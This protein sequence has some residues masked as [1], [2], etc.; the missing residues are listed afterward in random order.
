MKDIIFKDE[1]LDEVNDK[2]RLIQKTNGLTFGTDALLLAAF[3][4]KKGDRALELG[5]GSG[6]ISML[7]CARERFKHIVCAEVQTEYAE[8]IERNIVL[9]RLSER[10]MPLCADIRETKRLGEIGSF[11]AVFSNPPYMT[12]ESG[13]LCERDAKSI[14]R[15][16]LFG[17]IKDFA[18][19]ASK[20]LKFGGRFYCVYRTDRLVDLISAL[21]EYRL[22]PKRITFV[23]ARASLPPSMVLI[24]ARLGGKSDLRVTC[25]LIL[26]NDDGTQSTDYAYLLENGIL[27]KNFF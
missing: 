25:P 12:A 4:G 23:H 18:A 6:I 2:L 26:S 10:M 9:N 14:A 20:M 27:P 1:R 11:D 5:G 24:E 16:E 13:F 21:R 19:T 22:E 17:G 8:L 7:L 3:I 15:H